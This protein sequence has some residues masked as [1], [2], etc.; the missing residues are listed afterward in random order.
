M[1][2]RS[3]SPARS[4]A[5]RT[6]YYND[7][8]YDGSGRDRGRSDEASKQSRN[9]RV[10]SRSRSPK[11]RSR[12]RTP[13]QSRVRS[14]SRSLSRS[15]SRSRSH[16]PPRGRSLSRTPSPR[17]KDAPRS[18]SPARGRS[19]A[20]SRSRSRSNARP[21]STSRSRSPVGKHARQDSRDSDPDLTLVSTITI[22]NLTK[23]VTEAHIKE[24]LSTYGKI[25][26]ILFPINPRFRNN[27]GYANVE[28]ETRE[29]AL[30]VLEGWNGGQLDGEILEV[31]FAKKVVNPVPASTPGFAAERF[32]RN[33][34]LSPLRRGGR[35]RSP[36][37]RRNEGN[38]IP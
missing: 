27:M 28:F 37:R 5:D 15:R 9:P 8:P 2:S 17:P 19:V 11:S 12:S 30:V 22:K 31:T 35:P 25:K 26:S 14:R 24:I 38:L 10:G 32:G 36:P 33:R 20:G 29:E 13:S 16:S 4:S 34:Q 1:P 6:P 23:N 7:S 3:P 18:Q 21:R